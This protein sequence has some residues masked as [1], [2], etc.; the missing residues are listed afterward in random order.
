MKHALRRVVCRI[1]AG[2]SHRRA[3]DF[4]EELSSHV[5]F[6][7]EDLVA[8]GATREEARRVARARLGSQLAVR[9][10]RRDMRPFRVLAPALRDVRHELRLF[11][12]GRTP[13]LVPVL[14]LAFAVAG[15]LTLIRVIDGALL[16]P[17]PFPEGQRI[18]AL[19]P[20]Q[21]ESGDVF[22]R[23]P[24]ELFDAVRAE[25]FLELV[26]TVSRRRTV[27][28]A[29]GQ[30]EWLELAPLSQHAGSLLGLRPTLGRPLVAEDFTV[31]EGGAMPVVLSETFWETRFGRD[32]TVV[33]R[34]LEGEQGRLVVI[35]VA[36]RVDGI[37]SVFGHLQPDAFAPDLD[38]APADYLT[39][40]FARLRS[41]ISL[42]DARAQLIARLDVVRDAYPRL[43][44]VG[45]HVRSLR[46]QIYGEERPFHVVLAGGV[47]A[48][49]GIGSCNVAVLLVAAARRRARELGVRLSLG[50]TPG[51]L[52]R[53]LWVQVLVIGVLAWP[54]VLTAASL[55]VRLVE[56]L[57]PADVTGLSLAIEPWRWHALVVTATAGASALAGLLAT[58]A[59]YRNA[60]LGH[61][62]GLTPLLKAPSGYGQLAPLAIQVA[63]STALLIVG[64][65]AVRSVVGLAVLET[66]VMADDVYVM[67][68]RLP[69]V[70]FRE[71]SHAVRARWY[72]IR[73][74]IARQRG[75]DAA[76]LAYDVPM[77]P[78]PVWWASLR[79]TDGT[80]ISALGTIVPVSREF[81]GTMG[82]QLLEG[83]LPTGDEERAGL[84]VGIVSKSTARMY[85]GDESAIGKAMPTPWLPHPY[86]VVGVVNDVRY[87]PTLA[88]VPTLYV[89]MWLQRPIP[90]KIVVRSSLPLAPLAAVLREAV[91]EVEPRAVVPEPLRYARE[92]QR[93]RAR[94]TFLAQVFMAASAVTLALAVVGVVA[95]GHAMLAA[96][97]RE[98]GIRLALGE[99]G[100]RVTVRVIGRGGAAAVAGA[101]VGCLATWRL[102]LPIE[103]GHIPWWLPQ[104]VVGLVPLV[105]F[106]AVLAGSYA[107]CRRALR[108]DPAHLLRSE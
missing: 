52:R 60:A 31:V 96:R 53:R 40:P 85:W 16:R 108:Q 5:A 100:S 79:G 82:L 47:T 70:R 43:A 81:F 71:G 3:D 74:R 22:G 106:T 4:D 11:R 37:P 83:R 90:M 9:E 34:V 20:Y 57:L 29:D 2:W 21:L 28:F 46:D 105:A 13:L 97:R 86:E 26:S 77:S 73:D 93:W 39:A 62:G 56:R 45:L 58:V 8:A 54:L 94:P 7:E 99:P 101:F 67:S 72:A 66:G 42:A 103:T 61:E 10:A 41:G 18:V 48:L 64:G 75:I 14:V 44:G 12:R 30:A 91:L 19:T 80:D 32:R 23:I 17:L 33:G 51:G 50:D 107:W 88:T 49:V 78:R 6:H 63:L 98:I 15:A 92:L 24:A 38:A 84:P 35:G 36:A 104:M 89:P 1:L 76:A 87:S 102:P 55:L 65:N 25:E 68:P 69:V 59:A 27:W 95:V